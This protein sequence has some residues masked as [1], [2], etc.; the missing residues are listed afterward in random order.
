[1]PALDKASVIGMLTQGDNMLIDTDIPAKFK[2][3]DRIKTLDMKPKGHT[4]LARYVR[5]KVGVIQ[6]DHGVYPL[7]D[8]AIDG[9]D[10]AQHVYSVKFEAREL[11]GNEASKNDTLCID[12]WDDYMMVTT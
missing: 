5:N 10:K 3:G 11:W 12:L 9:N 6:R 1:M 2:V 8:S 4:R 7:P